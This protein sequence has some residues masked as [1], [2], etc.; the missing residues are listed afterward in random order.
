M[1]S[2]CDEAYRCPQSGEMECLVHGGF[3]VCCMDPSCPGYRKEPLRERIWWFWWVRWYHVWRWLHRCPD[4]G[5][6]G[7]DPQTPRWEDDKVAQM[8]GLLHSD[9]CRACGKK[10]DG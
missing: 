8:L 10:I 1:D 7:W 3:D 9:R 2:C 6:H 4:C 5:Q